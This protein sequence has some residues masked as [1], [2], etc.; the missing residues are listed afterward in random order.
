MAENPEKKDGKKLEQEQK[1]TNTGRRDALKSLATVP[2]LGALAYGLYK[3]K[4]YDRVLRNNILE[5]VNIT[6]VTPVLPE[7]QADSKQI[8]LGI[9]GFGIRGRQLARAAGFQLP[10][11]IDKL[12]EAAAKDKKDKRYQT[13]LDQENL[14]VVVNGV[15][16]I[17][18]TYAKEASEAGANVNREGTGGKMA[19]APK[20][21]RTYKELLA[22]DD[23]DAVI[24]GTPDHWHGPMTMKRQKQGSTFTAKSHS[25][26]P[27]RKHMKS[28]KRSRKTTSYS[29]WGTRDVK[30]RVITR[31]KM[32]L[33]K[34]C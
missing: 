31:Q 27:S 34:M 20:I 15:C 6:D 1:A 23:I 8:R 16:D 2:V 30:Q 33:R 3:K 13:Y 4:K 32:P 14:N 18:E 26:G 10:E 19:P 21:Y 5:E 28:G 29:N 22:A 25:P 24:I 12:K 17:F 9:I 7:T 11:T